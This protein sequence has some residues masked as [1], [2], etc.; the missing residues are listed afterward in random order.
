MQQIQQ[1]GTMFQMLGMMQQYAVQL[2]AKYGDQNALMQLQNMIGQVGGQM[3]QLPMR[4]AS[5]PNPGQEPHTVRKA[6]EQSA[7]ATQPD[8]V[9]AEGR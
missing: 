3:P 5:V 4:A 9:G 8:G 6:K 1:N 7:G 2:A